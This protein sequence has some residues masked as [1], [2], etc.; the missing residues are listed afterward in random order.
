MMRERTPQERLFD[1]FGDVASAGG[2]VSSYLP[3][4]AGAAGDYLAPGFGGIAGRLGGQLLGS[5]YDTM[6]QNAAFGPYAEA[7]RQQFKNVTVPEIAERF[8]GTGSLGSSSFSNALAQGATDLESQLALGRAQFG[9]QEQDR[10]MKMRELQNRIAEDRFKRNLM[11]NE[12]KSQYI[13]DRLTR[14][15]RDIE[16]GLSPRYNIQY[17]KQQPINWPVEIARGLPR[18][19]KTGLE[20]LKLLK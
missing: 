4:L 12:M 5:A 7:A 1:E 15:G 17:Q 9:Q 16:S 11:Q 20:L 19:T 2:G 10:A 8:A 6:S 3:L 13:R 14:A 18:A